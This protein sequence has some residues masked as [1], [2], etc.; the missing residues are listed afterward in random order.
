MQE[1]LDSAI[2][3]HEA[4]TAQDKFF[5]LNGKKY[6][7]YI[8]NSC[9][10]N[11][12][13][14]MK[15]NYPSAY[16]AFSA[17]SGDELGVNSRNKPP[18]MACFGSSSRMIFNLSKDIKDF[19]FE[20]KLP[21]T[22]GGIAHLDGYLRKGKTNIYVEAKC[23]E[24]YKENSYK[25]ERKYENFY[26][27]LNDN[28]ADFACDIEIIDKNQMHVNFFANNKQLVRFDLKQMICHLLAIA[29]KN[30]TSSAV[31]QTKFIYLL[32][33]PK[34]I[35]IDQNFAAQIIS[36]YEKEVD[37]CNSIPFKNLYKSILIYLSENK[38][39][40]NATQK[41]IADLADN[42]SF[43]LRDQTNYLS[44]FKF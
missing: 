35:E 27:Y 12:V 6:Y 2:K 39:I 19:C 23:R 41:F 44:E 9:W 37:E 34:F 5:E 33:N 3:Q 24:P 4:P 31:K 22:V 30:L 26:R 38:K 20:Y 13:E 32:F 7:N 36:T 28:A 11:F 25:I 10:Q 21:T 42:F 14:N 43:S 1:I 16:A 40:G 8:D 29:T 17:G 18:K 15:T